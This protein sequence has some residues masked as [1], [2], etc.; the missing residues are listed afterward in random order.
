M[1]GKI[2]AS[3][4][5]TYTLLSDGVTYNVLPRGLFKFKKEHLL[6]GDD[7]IVDDT[8]FMVLSIEERKNE[9]IRPKCS[10][11]D[12]L[13]I[14][15]SV[16][17]PDLSTELLYKFL[18]YGKM[19]NIQTDVIFTK[20][21]LLTDQTDLND[22]INDLDK[23][24]I[25][26]YKIGRNIVDDKEKLLSSLENKV[27]IFMGQTGVG[28]SSIINKI[29]P[30]FSRG[31][32]EYSNAL[33]RGKH[34]TKE[35]VLLPYKNGFIGDT[36]GFSSLDLGIYKEDLAM[37]FP[38]YNELYTECFYSNCLHQN[39]KDCK[40]KEKVNDGYLSLTSYKIYLKLLNELPYR[41]ERYK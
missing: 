26:S 25:H 18:T 5:G 41:K 6:V 14:V 19:N 10:N 21:D 40:V 32:G 30:N 31:I 27:T 16:K 35:V 1:R 17:E 13:Y 8:N 23:L 39:E 9:L 29:N 22:L 24:N 28:K 36:P 38:G 3:L 37:F 33:G 4:N 7:V 2:I 12:Q 20:I 34:K 15:M 11:I